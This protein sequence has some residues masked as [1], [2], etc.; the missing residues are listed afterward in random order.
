MGSENLENPGVKNKVQLV[1][2][3]PTAP[4]VPVCNTSAFIAC[5]ILFLSNAMENSLFEEA[6]E[7]LEGK[8]SLEN[9]PEAGSALINK[10]WEGS[11]GVQP[12]AHV[13]R[14]RGLG[15]RGLRRLRP[16]LHPLGQALC[17]IVPSWS[18]ANVPAFCGSFSSSVSSALGRK[19][20]F[21]RRVCGERC[22]RLAVGAELTLLGQSRDQKVGKSC[23]LQT[24]QE[25]AAG[26]FRQYR[27]KYT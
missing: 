25:E 2:L 22:R 8:L 18:T 10:P 6:G 3:I 17:G 20:G 5:F 7:D 4:A 26:F 16:G 19:E 12:M 23:R 14:N 15:A 24:A 13:S 27:N 9:F 21:N 11:S 1:P